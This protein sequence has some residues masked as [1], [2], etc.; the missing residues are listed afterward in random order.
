MDG[1]DRESDAI[2]YP[3]SAVVADEVSWEPVYEFAVAA[4]V[5]TVIEIP[6]YDTDGS[7]GVQ[8]LARWHYTEQQLI[9][10]WLE[11]TQVVLTGTNQ[12][13]QTWSLPSLPTIR[14]DLNQA[15]SG[16]ELNLTDGQ[17]SLTLQPGQQEL[18]VM[19]V[20]MDGN[21]SWQMNGEQLNATLGDLSPYVR[22]QQLISAWPVQQIA[23]VW[24]TNLAQ[25]LDLASQNW[26]YACGENRQPGSKQI[27][28]DGT[29]IYHDE[30]R[31]VATC[32]QGGAGVTNQSDYILA[33]TAVNKMGRELK[34]YVQDSGRQRALYQKL[35]EKE[36]PQK[37]WGMLSAPTIAAGNIEVMWENRVVVTVTAENNLQKATFYPAPLRWASQISLI[38]PGGAAPTA[39]SENWQWQAGPQTISKY[40]GVLQATTEDRSGQPLLMSLDQAYETG[41][42]A[43]IDGKLLEHVEV[44][45]WQNGWLIAPE[46]L[47]RDQSEWQVEIIYAPQK[48][49]SA[50]WWLVAAGAGVS[51]LAAMAVRPHKVKFKAHG[52]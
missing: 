24:P 17:K 10:E 4:P 29:V 37:Y 16:G 18:M 15:S 45:G 25:D 39:S 34:L 12:E 47:G 50:G 52:I 49:M 1:A 13:Q 38:P 6:T 14:Y 43:R 42:Q 32:D 31:M 48:L 41:W 35:L 2:V 36:Q 30:G 28:A 46:F 26:L 23:L 51:G 19:D 33:T 8:L 22:E 5:G 11:P 3:F 20:P 7:D 9:A 44:N 27:Q 40:L 21:F